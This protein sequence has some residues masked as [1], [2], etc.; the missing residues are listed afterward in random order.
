MTVAVHNVVPL[1][2]PTEHTL[3]ENL[4]IVSLPF[5]SALTEKAKQ[6]T[7]DLGQVNTVM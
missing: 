2:K 3:P 7:L 6:T 1:V 4:K 5:T